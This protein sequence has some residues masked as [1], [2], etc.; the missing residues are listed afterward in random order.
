MKNTVR[1]IFTDSRYDMACTYI[2]RYMDVTEIYTRETKYKLIRDWGLEEAIVYFL[3]TR[4]II[5]N[6]Q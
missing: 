2:V 1:H 4:E 6:I 3:N 5:I